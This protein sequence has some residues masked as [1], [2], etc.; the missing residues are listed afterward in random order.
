MLSPSS[1]R[2]R[3]GRE[4]R[5]KKAKIKAV[6]HCKKKLVMLCK[7]MHCRGEFSILLN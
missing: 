5:R 1:G 3:C 2:I 7:G 4:V 6:P